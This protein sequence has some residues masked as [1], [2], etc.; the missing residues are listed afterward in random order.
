MRDGGRLSAA[1]EILTDV[2]TRHR[3]VKLALKAWGDASR[4]AGSKDRAWV[5]G[6]VLD[7]LRRRR[8][9]AWRMG[10]DS[11]RAAVFCALH[12][13]WNWPVERIAEAAADAPHGPGA[14]SEAERVA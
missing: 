7:V 4:F 12:A 1:I 13:L 10:D 2:E 11:P 8:S 6:L 3:P 14:V 9:L 5:S